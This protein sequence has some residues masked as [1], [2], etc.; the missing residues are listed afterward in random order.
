MGPTDLRCP[1][2]MATRLVSLLGSKL[3]DNLEEC[4]GK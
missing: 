4:F 1:K 3:Q 2:A